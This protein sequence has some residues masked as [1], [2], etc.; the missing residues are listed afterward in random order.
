[1]K[2]HERYYFII[3]YL[4][5]FLDIILILGLFPFDTSYII[6]LS[7]ANKFF[8]A[9][10]LMYKTNPFITNLTIKF[11]QFDK[12]LVFSSALYLLISAFALAHI[13]VN[14]IVKKN[15]KKIIPSSLKV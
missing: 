2:Q 8:I 14:Y 6:Y 7:L 11:S 15:V 1:M 10:Y 13:D 9:L 5:Y 12:K 3:L 4:L